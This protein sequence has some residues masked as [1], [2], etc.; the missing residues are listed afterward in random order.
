MVLGGERFPVRLRV[1]VDG[2]TILEETYEPRGLRR[3]GAIEVL[4][5]YWLPPGEHQIDIW[6]IDDGADWQQVFAGTVTIPENGARTLLFDE[7]TGTFEPE[8]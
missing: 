5:T 1:Q 7:S 4:E 8:S 3:E 2:K 6:L